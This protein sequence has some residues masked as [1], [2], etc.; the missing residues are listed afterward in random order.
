MV[1]SKAWDWKKING[2]N[3]KYWLEPALESY[4]YV[5]RWLKQN[6][7]IFLDLGC[8]LGRH[9]IQFAQAGFNTFGFDLS[10]TSI[11]KTEEYAKKSSTKI[12]LQVGDMLN[13][14]YKDESFDCIFCYHVISHTD[15]KGIK[16]IISE[17]KRVLK[18]DGECY[19]TLCSKQSWGFKQNWPVVDEN[20][21]IRVEDG[22]ENGVPHF[23]ADFD[24]I[25][26]LFHEFQILKIFQV[27]D[28]NIDGRFSNSFHYHV[29]VK[30]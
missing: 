4:Y 23:Y 29:L 11:E 13:L 25:L 30:K 5:N 28:F 15:T 14:P 16:K 17:L 7:K 24:L 2:E 10:K 3:E 9:T 8:G 1:N 21:K 6:K 27:E 22:P 26:E 12:S 18:N 20:T 19:L